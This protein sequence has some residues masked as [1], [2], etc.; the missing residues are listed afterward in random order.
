MKTNLLFPSYFK[1]I[2]WLLA[3]PGL[4]LGY[5]FEFEHFTFRFL[6]YGQQSYFGGNENYTD[7]IAIT[8]IAIGFLF[9]SSVK[10]EHEKKYAH[11]WKAL[12]QSVIAA[13][14]ITVIFILVNVFTDVVKGSIIITWYFFLYQ[15]IIFICLLKY[16]LHFS[17]TEKVD[18]IP[19]LG[20]K[21]FRSLGLSILFTSAI[22]R[23]I[24]ACINLV[25]DP[26]LTIVYPLAFSGLLILV[27]SKE[28]TENSIIS[29]Y[30]SK[31]VQIAIYIASIIFLT[32][33]WLVYG[34]DY[35]GYLYLYPVYLWAA[36]SATFQYK[37]YRHKKQPQDI[38]ALT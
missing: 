37:L 1:Y 6:Q 8:L 33:T 13:T 12:Y 14:T 29:N 30:R 9:I 26:F 23:V 32:A 16:H 5:L 11:R 27:L 10:I 19:P 15:P 36:Y 4:V 34:F 3:V 25:S 18:V 28:K 35:L 17:N 21:F 2:G 7:E 31:S 24:Y 20:H 22:T 38:V